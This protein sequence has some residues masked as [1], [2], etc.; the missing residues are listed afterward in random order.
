MADS[1]VQGS[2]AFTCT[3]AEAALIEE[4]WQHASALVLDL[5]PEEPSADFLT[6]FPPKEGGDH[7][8]GFLEIFHDANF[9]DFGADL[10]V[11]SEPDDAQQSALVIYSL[12]DFQPDPIA[13]LIF[14]C[15][16]EILKQSPIGFDWSYSCDR[17]RIDHFG[18]GFCAIFPD[19]IEFQT[20]NR[21]LKRAVD[22][23]ATIEVPDPWIDQPEHP[24]SD[25][26]YEV[27][28][29]ETRLGYLDWIQARIELARTD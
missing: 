4:C 8:S 20:T 12:T 1:Y 9:P 26:T 18:G 29:G 17:P 22:G 16:Q 15:C 2:F 5:D 11:E 6:I 14:R 13:N 25:W 10:S 7:F 24:V 28:N 3:K 19:R 23:A 27:A 21:Q